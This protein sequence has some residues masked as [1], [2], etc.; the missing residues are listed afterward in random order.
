MYLLWWFPCH[1]HVLENYSTELSDINVMVCI[2][3]IY[4]KSLRAPGMLRNFAC[5]SWW[6]NHVRPLSILL[7]PFCV[8]NLRVGRLHRIEHLWCKAIWGLLSIILFCIVTPLWWRH[9]ENDRVSNHRR[10]DCLLNCLF[11]RGSKKTSKLSVT[12]FCKGNPLVT[13]EFPSQRAIDAEK[14]FHLMTSS[15]ITWNGAEPCWPVNGSYCNPLNDRRS[16]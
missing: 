7:T 14:C 1:A 11:K 4:I 2:Q 10:F 6:W 13:G 3:N 16:P 9:N 15:Y 12:G 8:E 5:V